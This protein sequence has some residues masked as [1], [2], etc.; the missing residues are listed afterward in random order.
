MIDKTAQTVIATGVSTTATAAYI[1]YY[2]YNKISHQS[3]IALAGGIASALTSV[4]LNYKKFKSDEISKSSAIKT[5]LKETTQGSIASVATIVGAKYYD[6]K[7]Y[8]GMMASIG[9][10]VAGVTLVEKVSSKVKI[11][12]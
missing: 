12:K 8:L 3:H 9:L 2:K 11:K 5:T 10:G 6:K 4:F 7:N 1:N